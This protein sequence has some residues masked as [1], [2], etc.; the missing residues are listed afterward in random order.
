MADPAA[1]DLVQMAKSLSPTALG[2]A[3][4]MVARWSREARN[5][6]WKALLRMIILDLPTMGALTIAAGSVAQQMNADTLTATGIGT[7]AGYAGSEILKT[8]LAW[9]AGKLPGGQG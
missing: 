6:G 7:C 1:H 8:L 2:V 5:S 3:A 4:G 9:R